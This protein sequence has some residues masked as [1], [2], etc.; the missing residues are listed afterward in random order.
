MKRKT[1]LTTLSALIFLAIPSCY[2]P[3]PG[4]RSTTRVVGISSL[5]YGY[6][7]VSV[8]GSPYYYH[9][10]S[11]YRRNQGRYIRCNR[12]H[13]Y[14]GSIGRNYGYRN[15]RVSHS[16]YRGSYGHNRYNPHKSIH[17]N[18]GSYGHR[19]YG[20]RGYKSNNPH[21]SHSNHGYN[22]YKGHSNHG[23]KHYNGSNKHKGHSSHGSNQVVSKP[24]SSHSS[25]PVRTMTRPTSTKSN[26]HKSGK[27]RSSR[28]VH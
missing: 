2:L 3:D 23:S 8:G 20:S 18:H 9:G 17:V 22:K 27:T 14:H 10:N 11:W 15:T 6:R 25:M 7:T 5:P 1:I 21:R 24:M 13:G 19:N 4:Y 12:P 16:P 26:S 28:L